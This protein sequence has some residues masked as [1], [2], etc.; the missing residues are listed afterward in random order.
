MKRFIISLL[1]LGLV[2]LGCQLGVHYTLDTYTALEKTLS[3]ASDALKI[4]DADAARHYCTEAEKFYVSREKLL[5]AFVVR[6][7]VNDI[8]EILSSLPPLA[9]RD[10]KEDFFSHVRQAETTISHLKNYQ[11]PSLY[12]LF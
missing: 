11:I 3:Q 2:L 7:T 5:T 12:N 8:G 1:L 4:G 9:E 10:T 6:D